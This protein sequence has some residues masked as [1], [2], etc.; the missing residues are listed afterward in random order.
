MVATVQVASAPKSTN[1]RRNDMVEKS[2]QRIFQ[3]E[4]RNPIS[5]I[6]RFMIY[7]ADF[8]RMDRIRRNEI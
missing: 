1:Y 6:I 5:R 8:T 2:S 3:I 7:I 4:I